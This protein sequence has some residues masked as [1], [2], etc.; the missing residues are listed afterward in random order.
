MTVYICIGTYECE[1]MGGM[2]AAIHPLCNP[3]V[4]SYFRVRLSIKYTYMQDFH[5]QTVHNRSKDIA[6]SL[7]P[8]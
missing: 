4:H 1:I 3:M 6:S 5:R 7:L 8:D 2:V